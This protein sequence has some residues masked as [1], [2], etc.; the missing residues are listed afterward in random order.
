MDNDDRKSNSSD[1]SFDLVGPSDP[2][3]LQYVSTG[4][5]KSKKEKR[6]S[7]KRTSSK[8]TSRNNSSSNLGGSPGTDNSVYDFGSKYVLPPQQPKRAK[9]EHDP[10]MPSDN[11]DPDDPL[12]A[13]MAEEFH[14][15]MDDVEM[16]E[17]MGRN[18]NNF[19]NTEKRSLSGLNRSMRTLK[20]Y[21]VPILL[22]IL[23]LLG[24][25]AAILYLAGVGKTKVIIEQEVP[26]APDNL[27][28]LCYDPNPSIATVVPPLCVDYCRASQCCWDPRGQ[29]TCLEGTEV[30]CPSYVQ[31]CAPWRDILLGNTK[32]NNNGSGGPHEVFVP[33]MRAGLQSAC[34]RTFTDEVSNECKAG[35]FAADCC[36]NKQA[37]S[38]C[39][40][41]TVS[42]CGNYKEVC[43]FLN[44]RLS[45]PPVP[46]NDAIGSDNN[47]WPFPEAPDGLSI[48]CDP[49]EMEEI[50]LHIC[51]DK[52]SDAECCWKNGVS[53][54]ISSYP[55]QACRDYTQA[56]AVLNDLSTAP[57]NSHDVTSTTPPPATAQSN[58]NTLQEASDD[59]DTICSKSRISDTDS[60]GEALI[61][62]EKECLKA[63]CCWQPNAASPCSGDAKCAGYDSCDI[64][65]SLFDR[66]GDYNPNTETLAPI[67]VSGVPVAASDIT[68]TCNP[69]VL[70]TSVNGGKSIVECEK[71]CL[72]GA[73]CWKKNHPTH[74]A[75][76]PECGA[77]QTPCGTNL[78]NALVALESSTPAPHMNRPPTPN[79][80][81]A[82]VAP[83]PS[84]VET[85]VPE[86]PGKI[87]LMCTPDVLKLNVD[88]GDFIIECEKICLEAACCW[89]EGHAT[90]CVG[91]PQCDAY[92]VPCKDNLVPALERMEAG[93]VNPIT[94]T[95][96]SPGPAVPNA[97]D[98]INIVC[99]TANLDTN[100]DGRSDCEA[101]CNQ[102][103]AKCCWTNAG[104]PEP[105]CAG[106]A[107]CNEYEPCG[108]LLT[109][110][111][112]GGTSGSSNTPPAPPSDLQET[113]K[114]ESILDLNGMQK[115][116][117]VC[118]AAACCWTDE[119]DA[120]SC[121]TS[122][123]CRTYEDECG[124][125]R[126]MVLESL[127]SG[128]SAS[129]GAGSTDSIQSDCDTSTTF[130]LRS[131]CEQACRPGQCCFDGAGG[132]QSGVDCLDYAPCS[133]LQG[134]RML[135]H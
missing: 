92:M 4:R 90:T 123:E 86:A 109:T 21:A 134:R 46:G 55:A 28:V 79:P 5:T 81:P 112:S 8:R 40:A 128:E 104:L 67:K 57:D 47:N 34:E 127:G 80:T 65:A 12:G 39:S 43:N 37:T 22:V 132:C 31:Q 14:D 60:G 83:P 61:E 102:A 41:D 96:P 95:T 35:C 42:N 38:I 91:A 66:P 72:V 119:A 115:C 105:E 114:A 97:P 50:S 78:V 93:A 116:R 19:G 129:T 2:S 62:C 29:H 118:E 100:P 108:N 9:E 110:L 32:P 73:C 74:C 7:S 121:K 133:F 94:P 27:S 98:N 16:R 36:W 101:A 33:P 23:F 51:A 48:Y 44:N 122:V 99:S 87:N 64:F 45:D 3:G 10:L 126:N 52:C 125:M 20:I 15:E 18:F 25:V 69:D 75:D 82:P 89:K 68:Q 117:Q 71:E 120:G 113:C 135:R 124:L 1:G 49:S 17:E 107:Q 13:G 30:N 77:Y 6:R 131:R 59:L 130:Y 53:S 63:S 26:T 85:N 54:C 106:V 56:C 76:A 11:Q 84:P 103:S 58:S 88:D 24:I 111:P 70:K